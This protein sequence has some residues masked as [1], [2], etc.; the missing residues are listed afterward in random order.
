V[1]EFLGSADYLLALTDQHQLVIASID[2]WSGNPDNRTTCIF[3]TTF[4]N[5]FSGWQSYN[6]IKD[7]VQFEELLCKTEVVAIQRKLCKCRSSTKPGK[8]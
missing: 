1:A 8:L 6:S 3:R 7:T 2:A 4:D 5:G